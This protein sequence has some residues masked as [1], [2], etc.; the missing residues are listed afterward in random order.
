MSHS[1]VFVLGCLWALGCA[2]TTTPPPVLPDGG[3]ARFDVSQWR[4][5]V[6]EPTLRFLIE[7]TKAHR[8]ESA[9]LDGD[10]ERELTVYRTPDGV[11]HWVWAP[12]GIV[13]FEVDRAPDGTE[14][15]RLAFENYA[16]W[17]EVDVFQPN[18]DAVFQFDSRNANRFDRRITRTVVDDTTF[19]WVEERVDGGAFVQTDAWQSTRWADQ[20]GT[21]SDGCK[22]TRNM[23]TEFGPFADNVPGIFF[24]D[25]GEAAGCSLEEKVKLGKAMQCLKERLDGC[26]DRINSTVR[27]RLASRLA[28]DEWQLG[29]DNPCPGRD[30][31]SQPRFG[32]IAAQ[33]NFSKGALMN[34]SPEELCALLIHEGLHMAESPHDPRAHDLQGKDEIY[35][36]AHYCGGCTSRGPANP[37]PTPNQD[38]A[39]CAANDAKRRACGVKRQREAVGQGPSVCTGGLG[40][41]MTPCPDWQAPVSRDCNDKPIGDPETSAGCC[42]MCPPNA[43]TNSKPC[44]PSTPTDSCSMKAPECP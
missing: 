39:T 35:A 8:S 43:M 40:T 12:G 24:V 10:G 36:C 34:A 21:G 17:A 42:T 25:D 9:D 30:A 37:R 44:N 22:G 4:D 7:L 33:T 16:Y 19:Q 32:N 13:A 6:D 27:N 20:G 15:R 26:L 18:G 1:R 31:T 41:L 28:T 2:P 5:V 11:T 29:C 14:T 38:C 23:P 3:S